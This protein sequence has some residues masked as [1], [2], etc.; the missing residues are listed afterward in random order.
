[1][2]CKHGEKL[3]I[4]VCSVCPKAASTSMHRC[5]AA[6]LLIDGLPLEESCELST[7]FGLL[8]MTEHAF[9]IQCFAAA[10]RLTDKRGL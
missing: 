3:L 10:L 4:S 2:T 9:G 6:G 5:S 7:C 1:M 8:V